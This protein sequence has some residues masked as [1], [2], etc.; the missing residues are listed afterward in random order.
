MAKSRHRAEYDAMEA[1]NR[2]FKPL[3]VRENAPNRSRIGGGIVEEVVSNSNLNVF[4]W[5]RMA[6]FIQPVNAHSASM[7]GIG[8]V[9]VTG[10]LKCRYHR[11][12]V[13][14]NTVLQI[15][16]SIEERESL[17]QTTLQQKQ[18]GVRIRSA[19]DDFIDTLAEGADCWTGQYCVLTEFMGKGRLLLFDLNAFSLTARVHLNHV[20]AVNIKY[21]FLR[22]FI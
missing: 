10:I 21:F 13:P 4:A 18:S 9:V 20:T 7:A 15:R 12:P 22:S 14:N 2:D 19:S 3:I 8:T 17:Q 16:S 6:S 5:K 11:R 1:M